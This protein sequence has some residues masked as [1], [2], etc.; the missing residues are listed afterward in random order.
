MIISMLGDDI[1]IAESGFEEKVVINRRLPRRNKNETYRGREHLEIKE[2]EAMIQAS[3]KAGRYGKRDA[4][5]ILLMYRHGLRV[6]EV[7][8]LRWDQVDFKAKQLYVTR[9]KGGLAGMHPLQLE[10]IRALKS[11]AAAK[12][13]QYVFI[14]ERGTPFKAGVVRAIVRRA[15]ELAEL[16]LS[17]HPHMLRHACGFALLHKK[18]DLRQIQ[19]WLGHVNL[20]N[21]ARYTALLPTAFEGIWD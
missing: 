4:A 6:A 20:A 18:R 9:V 10:E 8:A 16:P 13:G 7:C 15:G 11:L 21:T 19:A 1:G 12:L 2:V 17:V 5:M 14:S 3:A